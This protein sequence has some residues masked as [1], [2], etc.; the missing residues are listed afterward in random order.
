[1]KIP[2]MLSKLLDN[3]F[4]WLFLFIGNLLGSVLG[5]NVYS[6]QLSQS[7]LYLWPM[8]PDCPIQTAGF[9][10]FLV[11]HRLRRNYPV[12]N[13]FLFLGLVKYA[14]WTLVAVPLYAPQLTPS[15]FEANSVL[16]YFHTGMILD[17]IFL[18]PSLKKVQLRFLLLNNIWL[19]W[20]DLSDY[21][22]GTHPYVPSPDFLT[23]LLF[24]NIVMNLL[25][26]GVFIWLVKKSER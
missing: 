10:I 21:F 12:L 23:L 4:V 7:P 25:L 18:I 20:N 26:T 22:I 13:M 24:Q 3:N 2:G 14:L 1:M 15:L 11:L 5:F 8:I 9:C 17:A 6:L 16:A 19:F